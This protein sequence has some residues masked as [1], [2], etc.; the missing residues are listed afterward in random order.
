MFT[1]KEVIQQVLVIIAERYDGNQAAFASDNSMS[2]AYVSDVIR[3]RR[4]PGKKVLDLLGLK[5][6]I[7]Y[8]KVG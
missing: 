5:K 3:G 2:A 1:K 4:D 7:R 6:V 8:E